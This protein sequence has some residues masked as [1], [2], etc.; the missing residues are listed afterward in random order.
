MAPK[1]WTTN[2]PSALDTASEHPSVI[3]LTDIVDASHINTLS[4][5]ILA[6]EEMVG[7]TAIESGSLRDRLSLSKQHLP[8]LTWTDVTTISVAAWPGQSSTIYARLQ[9]NTWR[10]FTGT[11]TFSPAVSG[12]GGLDTGSEA[13]V[14]YYL[15]LVPTAADD[16][17]LTVVGSATTPAT[18]PTGYT[19]FKYIGAVKNLSGSLVAFWHGER[20][21]FSWQKTNYTSELSSTS[22]DASPVKLTLTYVPAT[23]SAAE[24]NIKT[25]A[26]ASGSVGTMRIWVDNGSAP[27]DSVDTT[28]MCLYWSSSAWHTVNERGIVPLAT[29][30]SIYYRKAQVSGSLNVAHIST[31]GWIDAYLTM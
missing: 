29:P 14:W 26:S 30:Q 8:R 22:W 5:T 16:S 19:N 24:V 27:T 3:N 12:E 25:Q 17:L 2:Y 7:S 15:Y 13:D 11:L 21:R 18:G 9:D 10:S 31:Y 6:L 28:V 23:A 1:L 20:D 4:E